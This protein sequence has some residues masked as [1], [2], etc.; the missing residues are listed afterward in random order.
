MD[1]FEAIYSR[2]SVRKY[3][4]KEISDELLKE[5]LDAACMAPSATN[6]QPWYFV[7]IKDRGEQEWVLNVMKNVAEAMKS[8]LE[9]RFAAYP[10][11]VRDTLSFMR[12]LG[13]ASAYILVFAQKDY[14]EGKQ[15]AIT[16]SIA[17]ACENLCLAAAARGLGTCWMTAPVHTGFGAEFREKYASDKGQMLAMLSLGYKASNPSTPKR[18]DDRYKII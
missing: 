13:G 7:A 11:V 16:Q 9:E 8:G 2:R 1:T 5:L 6:L 3:D 18:K 17:A 4:G 12:S 10:E 15:N 14:G